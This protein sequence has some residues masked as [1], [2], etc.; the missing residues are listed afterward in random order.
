LSILTEFANTEDIGE[1]MR[2]GEEP[3]AL[4]QQGRKELKPGLSSPVGEETESGTSKA[5]KIVR[6]L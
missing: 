1:L 4:I 3:D 6:L 2:D 5:L